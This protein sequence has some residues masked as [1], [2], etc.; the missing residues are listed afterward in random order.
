MSVIEFP[1]RPEPETTAAEVLERITKNMVLLKL[2]QD[3]EGRQAEIAQTLGR[4]QR[5]IRWMSKW[6]VDA[7][8]QIAEWMFDFGG[9]RI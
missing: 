2:H 6:C 1:A 9:V 5:D 3:R 7:D 8:Q 4:L